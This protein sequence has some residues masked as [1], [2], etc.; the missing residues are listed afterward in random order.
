[1]KTIQQS[2]SIAASPSR[3]F[4]ALTDQADIAA[5]SGSPA[6]MDAQ[7]GR[8]FSLWSGGAVG[9]NLEVEPDRKLVQ[10]WRLDTWKA[11]STVTFTLRPRGKKT[12][13]ELVHAG[14][15]DEEEAEIAQGWQDYYLGAMK[16][17]LEGS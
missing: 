2:Y 5:W 12:I 7:V 9:R 11:D 16:S 17:Y 10:S 15:P 6:T 3:V 8:Q 14:V 1:M 4:Q 13:V